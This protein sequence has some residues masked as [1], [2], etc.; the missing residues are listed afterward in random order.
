MLKK[1]ILVYCVDKPQVGAAT[2]CASVSSWTTTEGESQ[3]TAAALMN[4]ADLTSISERPSEWAHWR[5]HKCGFPRR[6]GAAVAVASEYCEKPR[7]PSTDLLDSSSALLLQWMAASFH[8]IQHLFIETRQ[9]LRCCGQESYHQW[10][11]LWGGRPKD[12]P[13]P[14]RRHAPSLRHNTAHVTL[15]LKLLWRPLGGSGNQ[16][17]TNVSEV[18]SLTFDPVIAFKCKK[19]S[20]LSHYSHLDDISS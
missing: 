13:Y 19:I 3:R 12:R 14:P 10:R 15:L 18:G 17:R 20:Y 6:R 11:R 8:V 7:P 1:V 5:T 16:K 4:N 9:Q 2:V